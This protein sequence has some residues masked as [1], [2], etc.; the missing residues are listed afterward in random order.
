MMGRPEPQR[1]TQAVGMP[2]MS[3]STA[4]PFFSRR[5]VRYLESELLVGELAERNTVSFMTCASLR[6][7]STPLVTLVFQ[8]LDTGRC[9][10]RA[11]LRERS[12]RAS[13]SAR[14]RCSLKLHRRAPR[15]PAFFN[16]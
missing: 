9:R 15:W 6:R 14:A 4:K 16:F 2:A 1:R 5:S 13:I 7:A 11:L 8:C 12:A 10:R 3:R